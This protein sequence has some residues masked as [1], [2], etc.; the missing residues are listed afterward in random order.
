MNTS[1]CVFMHVLIFFFLCFIDLKAAESTSLQ[2]PPGNCLN[3][4]YDLVGNYWFKLW[5]VLVMSKIPLLQFALVKA[6]LSIAS[7]L[8]FHQINFILAPNLTQLTQRIKKYLNN[9]FKTNMIGTVQFWMTEE[10]K[11]K[12]IP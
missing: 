12:T 4:Q 9:Q 1:V 2:V 8:C 10:Q 11:V 6:M 7:N 5:P 3:T